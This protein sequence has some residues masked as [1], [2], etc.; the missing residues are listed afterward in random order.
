MTRREAQY[1]KEVNPVFIN[2]FRGMLLKQAAQKRASFQMQ[3]QDPDSRENNAA[4]IYFS[5]KETLK[6]TM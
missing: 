1:P 5:T 2:I 3:S 6:S 4:M